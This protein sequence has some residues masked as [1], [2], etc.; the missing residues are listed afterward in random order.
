[1]LVLSRKEN[2]RIVFPNLGVAVEI[3]RIS[4][5]AVRI[6]VDAPPEIR[7]LREEITQRPDARQGAGNTSAVDQSGP[8]CQPESQDSANAREMREFR[9][10]MRN[11]LN[12]TSLALH[13]M[14]R[15]LELGMTAQAEET[16]ERT[17]S[18][19]QRL[20]SIAAKVP[21]PGSRAP[22]TSAHPLA[23]LVDDDANERE[24]LAGL[25]RLHGYQVDIVE[26]GKA[27]L[28]YLSEHDRPDCVLLDMEMPRMD[29][30]STISAIRRNPAFRDL[31]VFAI[32]GM[33]PDAVNVPVGNQGIDHWFSKP[34]KP[35]EF[36]NDLDAEMR[37]QI[38]AV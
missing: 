11:L 27:A 20:E 17:L 19:F 12:T 1:M 2:Q 31:K 29:G 36:V 24:L 30:K 22:R 25:L 14:Q 37:R 6:G 28:E 26:D 7:I 4:G 23:L 3:L 8:V 32:T 10:T 5:N 13:L 16:L 34:L 38:T 35:V 9:H 18:E 15:Q 33:D 21:A